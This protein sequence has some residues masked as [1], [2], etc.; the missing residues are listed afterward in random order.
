MI[1]NKEIKISV[2]PFILPIKILNSICKIEVILIHTKFNR[3]GINQNIEGINNRP[4]IVLN[5][6]NDKL[7]KDN[8][9]N[10]LNKFAIIFNLIWFFFY[11]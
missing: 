2:I 10:E 6:F 8:G 3:E 11:L 9:S 5:Q 7:R 1:E 4:K